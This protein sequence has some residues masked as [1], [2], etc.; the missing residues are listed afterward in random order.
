MSDANILF[1]VICWMC[2]LIFWGIAIWAF[3]RKDPMHFWSGST[4][5]PEEIRD[6]PAY[7]RA[8]GIMW[9]IYAACLLMAG[10]VSLFSIKTGSILLFIIFLPGIAVLIITYNRIYKKYRNI[11]ETY[12]N[13]KVKTTIPKAFIAVIIVILGFLF[14]YSEK[15]PDVIIHDDHVQIKALYGL[16]IDF[17]EITDISLIDKSMKEIGTGIRVNGYG[18]FGETLKGNFKSETLGDTL[19]FVQSETSPTIKIERSG[20]KDIYISFR[21]SERTEQLYRELIE[22]IPLK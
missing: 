6:I 10:L 13:S 22:K 16:D 15:E 1:A 12:N 20:K 19:L 18:G 2:S 14:Y 5:R 3:K 7:N 8:N 11:S 4:V 9:S 17:S 21:D